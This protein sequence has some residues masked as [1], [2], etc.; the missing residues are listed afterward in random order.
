MSIVVTAFVIQLSIAIVAFVLREEVN[1]AFSIQ[2]SHIANSSNAATVCKLSCP[3][4]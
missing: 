2:R 3:H 1:S 4:S